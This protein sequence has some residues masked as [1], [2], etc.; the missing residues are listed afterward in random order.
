MNCNAAL[1]KWLSHTPR[2]ATVLCGEQRL[3]APKVDRGW[4]EIAET[5]EQLKPDSIVCVDKNGTVLRAKSFEYFFP[6]ED[7]VPMQPVPPPTTPEQATLQ[8]FGVL[9]ANAHTSAAATHGPILAA[10][11]EFTERLS[12]RLAK[13][14]G[15]LDKARAE[16][17]SLESELAELQAKLSA[18]PPGDDLV[19]AFTQGMAMR[20]GAAAP[21]NGAKS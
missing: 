7:D 11:M 20:Q 15:E 16:I 4:A 1:R 18:P 10:A 3:D 14:E 6:R 17:V 13:T 21:G 5:I 12:A 19:S 9:L 2:P 8:H